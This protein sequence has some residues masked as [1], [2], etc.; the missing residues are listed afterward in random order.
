MTELVPNPA[1]DHFQGR[2]GDKNE[3]IGYFSQ[4]AQE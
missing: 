3:T 4:S 1:G 2:R